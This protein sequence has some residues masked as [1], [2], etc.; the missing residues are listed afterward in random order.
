MEEQ[1]HDALFSFG[2]I[3]DVQCGD[4]DDSTNYAGTNTRHFRRA[5]KAFEN[6]VTCWNETNKTQYPLTFIVQLGDFL[7]G[8]NSSRQVKNNTCKKQ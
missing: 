4:M 2:A 6:A 1:Q 8:L 5:F 3:A 7:D